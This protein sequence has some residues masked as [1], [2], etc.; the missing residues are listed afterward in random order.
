MDLYNIKKAKGLIN[1]YKDP[2]SISGTELALLAAEIGKI[3][4]GGAPQREELKALTP[5]TLATKFGGTVSK[6]T[7]NP[8][9]ANAGEFIKRYDNYLNTLQKEAK[10]TISE[11]YGRVG[12]M[13]HTQMGEDKYQNYKK[14]YLDP[15]LN[16]E[17]ASNANSHP[18]DSEAVKW[19]K[20]NPG[21][22]A[23][24]ILKMNGVQ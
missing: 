3:A 20:A 7:S 6:F 12:D 4:Q 19:A 17:V 21:D 24:Q 5:D 10:N 22:K 18:Q 2:N 14:V 1:Q 11:K 9:G 23:N 13:M 16:D 8:T 15:Y